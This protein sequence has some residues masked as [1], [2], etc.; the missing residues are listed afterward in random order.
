MVAR[1]GE[2]PRD[3]QLLSLAD[4]LGLRHPNE[5]RPNLDDIALDAPFRTE[6]GDLSEG[7]IVF[8]AAI[9]VPRVVDRVC[10]DDDR[11][12]PGGLGEPERVGPQDRRARG[13][14]GGWT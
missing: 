8:G 6:P 7:R 10:R 3:P 11:L 14:V 13:A 9:D 2:V 12:R 5:R 4:N 1:P